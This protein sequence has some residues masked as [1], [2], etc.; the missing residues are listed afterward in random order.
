MTSK[1]MRR[2][3]A[4]AILLRALPALALS[5]LLLPSAASGQSL[6]SGGGLGLLSEPLD[7]RSRALGGAA[8]GLS[9]WHLSTTDPAAAAGLV[10][11]TASATLQP[12]SVRP[13]GEAEAGGSRFPQLGVSYP[14]N[15]HVFSL[16]FGSFL[17][18]EW[19]AGARREILLSGEPVEVVDRY[20]SNGGIGQARLGW[21]MRI[22]P[23]LAVG[24]NVGSYVGSMERHFTR[25][26]DPGGV[27]PGVEPY[28]VS[29]RW[30]ASGA[31]A[32]A[33]VAWDPSALLRV[34]AAVEWSGRMT[35]DPVAPTPGEAEDYPMPLTVRAGAT[36]M[37][38]DGVEL[39]LA[40]SRADWSGTRDALEDGGARGT[41]WSWAG[42]AEWSGL[43]LMGRVVPL[44]LGYG[45]RQLPFH[46]DG[47]A[48]DE[49]AL[50]GGFGVNLVQTEQALP[51]ARLGFGLER[52]SRSAGVFSEDYWRVSVTLRLAGS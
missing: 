50:T 48:A 8:I 39:T 9:G 40:G 23:R 3:A 13:D 44:R 18:Q 24:A 20:T 51:V 28:R 19:Q 49:S 45:S 35:L 12:S 37:L 21:A 4:T 38:T 30:R 34:A 41:A 2:R 15:R 25:E 22:A 16:Q 47:A 7:A 32:A 42:G 29:G 46:F 26:L 6:F 11:S 14:F 5:A 1:T 43:T 31:T 27:G 36:F 52:G 33:G 10:L 17:D